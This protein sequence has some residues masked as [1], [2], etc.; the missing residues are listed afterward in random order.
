M[1][2]NDYLT[3]GELQDGLPNKD[4]TTL[5]TQG[6]LIT[7]LAT[8]LI[9]RVSRTIDIK[10]QREPG[11]FAVGAD[12]TRYYD[13]PPMDSFLGLPR[14]D[15]GNAISYPSLKIDDIA[16]VTSVAVSQNGDLNNYTLWSASD[17]WMEPLNAP[18]YNEP[19][20]RI[21]IDVLNGGQRSFFWYKKGVRVIGKFGFSTAAPDP[22]KQAAIIMCGRWIKRA[23]LAYAD[24]YMAT[25][26]PNPLIYL[27]T[28]DQDIIDLL[29]PYKRRLV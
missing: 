24:R 4:W 9:T 15:L 3:L 19:Y 1:T 12:D 28:E 14:W 10:C 5:N 27:R 8:T 17:Y 11:A 18:S 26:K 23:D 25:D 2:A 29:A 20:N 6:E 16:A 22:I 21:V 13:G 7:L